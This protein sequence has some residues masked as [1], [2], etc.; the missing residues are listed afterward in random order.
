MKRARPIGDRNAAERNQE[1]LGWI[2]AK[3]DDPEHE[4]ARQFVIAWG[5]GPRVTLSTFYHPTRPIPPLSLRAFAALNGLDRT[6]VRR[7]VSRYADH[8]AQRVNADG[9]ALKPILARANYESP[10][11]R[12]RS[13]VRAGLDF[14]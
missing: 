13:L 1:A 6:K 14:G 11:N 9:G 12:G 10:R 2:V 4:D 5:R 8:V 7:M 3:E